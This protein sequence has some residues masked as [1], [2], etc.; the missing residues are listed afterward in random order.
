[1][2]IIN[3]KSNDRKFLKALLSFLY[4]Y[5]AVD[6]DSTI[7]TVGEE[8]SVSKEIWE[9]TLDEANPLWYNDDVDG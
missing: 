5:D 9:K 2:T 3:V 7:I 8:V 1:M 4:N 6:K